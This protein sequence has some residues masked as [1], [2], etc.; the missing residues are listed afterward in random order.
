M[1]RISSVDDRTLRAVVCLAITLLLIPVAVQATEDQQPKKTMP[2]QATVS[3]NWDVEGGGTRNQGSMTM[4]LR[5]TA[6]LAEEVSVMDQAAPPGTMITYAAKGVEAN[7]T[8]KETETQENPPRGCSAVMAEYEGS[9]VFTLEE[10][11]SAMTSGLNIRKMGSLI[12]N[13]MLQLVPPEA[14]GMMIDYYDF[15]A[16]AMKQK[17]QGRRR[18]WHDC[19]F[20]GHTREFNPTG[21]TIR[22]RITEDGKMTGSR[23][24]SVGENSGGPSFNIR[25]SDLPQDLERRPLVPEPD[26]GGDVTYEVSWNF[27]E[28]EPVVEIQRKEGPSWVPLGDDPVEVKVGEKIELRGK[29]YPEQIDTEKGDWTVPGKRVEGFTVEGD[30]GKKNELEGKDLEQTPT[31]SFHWYDGAEG[32]QVKYATTTTEGKNLV[33]EAAFNVQEPELKMHIEEPSCDFVKADVVWKDDDGLEHK[34]P[35]LLCDAP[36]SSYSIRF[37]HDPLPVKF[38]GRTQFVQIVNTEGLVRR[39]GDARTQCDMISREGL[40]ETYPYSAGPEATDKP[41]VDLDSLDLAVEVMHVFQMSLMYKPNS[42]GAIFVP[43]RETEWWWGGMARRSTVYTDNW[44]TSGSEMGSHGGDV[45]AE[46]FLEWD[47]VV[48]KD[49][50]WEGCE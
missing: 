49:D 1:S 43:I 10:I 14:R 31:V 39:S 3:V 15:F 29:V 7:Y 41:G 33:G 42:E 50:V 20:V 27:G 48:R 26:G 32:L 8:Y 24:W 35:E 28:V 44:D 2:I 5:G 22:F 6:N 37:H 4:R 25:I 19:D 30:T 18:G 21:L 11:N 16:V 23:S 46:D 45:Q 17:V 12:P 38:P 34:D 40:D 9:G 13:G 36:G 47:Q